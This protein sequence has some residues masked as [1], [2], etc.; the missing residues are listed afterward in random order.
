MKEFRFTYRNA[1]SK[2]T[3]TTIVL[4]ESLGEAIKAEHG[5]TVMFQKSK[6]PMSLV[7]IVVARDSTDYPADCVVCEHVFTAE[8]PI[9]ICMVLSR[10][11]RV[12]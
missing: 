7:S 1:K 3:N 6:P 4:A 12:K 2:K 9:C 11:P 10:F 5:S 8:S